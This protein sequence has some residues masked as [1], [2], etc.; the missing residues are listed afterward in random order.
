MDRSRG[1]IT[2]T[3]QGFHNC[4]QSSQSQLVAPLE[5]VVTPAL[6]LNYATEP[7]KS[8]VFSRYTASRKGVQR[9]S[10]NPYSSPIG[11][12]RIPIV[13]LPVGGTE[14]DSP[15][16]QILGEGGI[17]TGDFP[18]PDRQLLSLLC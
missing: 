3:Y 18:I 7:W 13:I 9:L 6:P 16:F 12:T 11:W 4:G 8:G 15:P 5:L 10:G 2:R 14:A 1:G 17:R